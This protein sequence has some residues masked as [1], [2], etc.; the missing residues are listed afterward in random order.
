MC[1]CQLRQSSSSTNAHLDVQAAIS[2]TTVQPVTMAIL[3][4]ELLASK[5]QLTVST[6]N[7]WLEVK[8]AFNIVTKNA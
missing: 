4:M 5:L 7:L 8:F 6:M 1:R 2:Q 3:W